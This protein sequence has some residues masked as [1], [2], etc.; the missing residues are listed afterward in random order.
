VEV[1]NNWTMLEMGLYEKGLQI[2]GKNRYWNWNILMI[3]IFH[4]SDSNKRRIW[5]TY[6]C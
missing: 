1:A 5:L 3:Q 2:F 6:W 4:L